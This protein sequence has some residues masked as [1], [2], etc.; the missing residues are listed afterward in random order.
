MEFNKSQLFSYCVNTNISVILSEV[1]LLVEQNLEVPVSH[2]T[3]V[4]I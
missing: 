3:S 2:Q 4:W 1:H